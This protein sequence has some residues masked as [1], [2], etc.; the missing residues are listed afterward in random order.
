MRKISIFLLLLC[1]LVFCEQGARYLIITNDMFYNEVQPL[2]NWKTKKG[3]TA[4]VVPLS[5]TGSGVAQIKSYIQNAYNTWNPRPEYVLLVGSGV[6]LPTTSNSDDYYVDVAGVGNPL[7]ELS[8]GRF[9]CVYPRHCSTMVAKTI[10]YE[11]SLLSETTW[12]R[13]GTTIVD[14]DYEADSVYWADVRYIHSLWKNDHYIQIDSFSYFRGDSTTDVVNAI[15]DGR[16]FVVQRGL[17][18]VNW[19]HFPINPGNLNNG[20][21][22]PVVIS[23][24]CATMS[25]SD[26][27]Y[28]GDKFLTAGS[29]LTPKGAVGFFGTTIATSGP[30]LGRLRGTVVTG[31]FH[32]VFQESIYKLGDATKRAKYIL[33]SIHPPYY[34]ETRYKEWNLFGDPE[35]AIYTC[36]PK[37]LTVIHDTIIQTGPQNY[38][39]TVRQAGSAVA[40]AL[41]CVMMDST[42]YQYGYTDGTGNITFNI[43]SPYSGTISVTVTA[44]NCIPYE[45]NVQILP[46]GNVHD[47]AVLSIVAPQGTI[48]T[49]NPVVPKAKVRNWGGYMDTF[50]ITFKIGNVYNNT[51]A[52]VILGGGDTAT[53]SFPNWNSVIGDYAVMSYISFAHDQWHANDTARSFITVITPNDVGVEAILNPDTI[54]SLNRVTIPRAKIRNYG[55]LTQTNFP[56]VC[57]IIGR[58]G[59]SQYTNIQTISSLIGNDTMTLNFA[60]WTPTVIETCNVKISTNLSGDENLLNDRKIKITTVNEAYLENFE[61]CD[62]NYRAT[63]IIGGW[64]WG[65]P[66]SG[67]YQA[68]LGTNCW[69]TLLNG[70]YPIN[71]NWKLIS[72]QMTANIDNPVLKFWHWYQMNDYY[73]GGNVKISTDS[74]TSWS[75]LHPQGGYTGTVF[76]FNYGIPNES[77]YTAFSDWTEAS[78]TLP[79]LAG[80]HFF[81][82]WHFGSSPYT[83][84]AGWY[85]DDITG[86][87]ISAQSPKVNDV[88]LDSIMYPP[89]YISLNVYLQP[90]ALVKNFGILLQNNFP[91]VCSIV[92][93]HGILRYTDTKNITL[94]A[95]RDTIIYFASWQPI[96]TEK[97]T[98]KIRTGLNGDENQSN[99]K[100]ISFCE[101]RWILFNEGFEEPY[102][103]PSGWVTYNNDGGT[104]CWVRGTISPNSG[105]ASAESQ[106]ESSTLR[107][108]DWLVTPSI[109]IPTAS[110]ELRYWCHSHNTVNF[111]SLEVR[112]SATGNA[113]S[114]FNTILGSFRFNNPYYLENIIPLNSYTGQNIYLAFINKGLLQRKIY[115]D[116]IMVKGFTMSV[117]EQ[118]PNNQLLTTMLYTVK[119]N[120]II[121]RFA[122]ISFSLAEPLKASLKMY[123]ASGRIVKTLVNR[124]FGKGIYNFIWDGKT[125]Q[126]KLVAEGVYFY[127]LE[128]PKQKFTKKLIL[129]R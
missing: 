61:E 54:H 2:A 69:A 56:V 39:V 38:N 80:Q 17:A 29:V 25:L 89:I 119:P 84:G 10:N 64:Q 92:N 120:P 100:K 91:V 60:P 97:C 94:A 110:A 55:I 113:I 88:G 127:T 16:V 42:I 74:G 125:D 62:G 23:G 78:F 34:I 99:D 106:F 102:F 87:G 7:I 122:T 71:A 22:L 5:V 33:D 43:Y 9:P 101:V 24:T 19:W 40:N 85:V 8:V 37:P 4:K 93:S 105:A 52:S 90:Q 83:T 59:I 12:Y 57:S 67:P 112:L 76:N 116:D 15:N 72:S 124:P 63:P 66:N 41:V 126:S 82:R 45:K 30:G 81:I 47:I 129:T 128:I 108:D 35:L 50:N 3:L 77:C 11:R 49:G 111:E 46:G 58:A 107:N 48:V 104:K 27:G 36:V 73:D 118:K 18:T 32:A 86:N 65:A 20:S 79:V 109:N 13:K 114:D 75:I 117:E 123:D 68:H 28:L 70:N 51:I 53:I 1:G 31:F 21:K 98:V 121:N 96:Q 26:T 44:Q 115:L 14:E 95:S 103:P 6:R